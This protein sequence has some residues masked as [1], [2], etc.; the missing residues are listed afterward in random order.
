MIIQTG[1]TYTKK[2]FADHKWSNKSTKASTSFVLMCPLS[3]TKKNDDRKQIVI[4]L[5]TRSTFKQ[6][7]NRLKKS[8]RYPI[9]QLFS[10]SK[11]PKV[12]TKH[13]EIAK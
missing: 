4:Y 9:L 5:C 11:H 8:V 12:L 3:N 2:P 6:I 13:T 10:L 7:K 1:N